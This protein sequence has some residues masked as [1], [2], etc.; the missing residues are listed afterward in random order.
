ME[1]F[2]IQYNNKL[3]MVEIGIHQTVGFLYSYVLDQI[4]LISVDNIVMMVCNDVILGHHPATFDQQISHTGFGS[5]SMIFVILNHYPELTRNYA[6]TTAPLYRQWMGRQRF[7]LDE[8]NL[9]YDPVIRQGSQVPTQSTASAPTPESLLPN[10]PD[11]EITFRYD[12]TLPL[13]ALM[14]QIMPLFEDMIYD[15][16]DVAVTLT[17]EQYRKLERKK[18]KDVAPV[19]RETHQGE[20]PYTECPITR[21]KFTD[22]SEV[23]V[24][25]CGH[26]FYENGIKPWLL[27]S[28]TKCPCCKAELREG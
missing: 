15:Q 28:S 19:Y 7:R 9:S 26:Y 17:P 25:K 22:E 18:F 13:T 1:K 2:Y 8:N 23:I 10:E 20:Q 14:Q 24:L 16:T 3:L 27:N 11:T 12:G 21:E 4:G 5:E 6:H